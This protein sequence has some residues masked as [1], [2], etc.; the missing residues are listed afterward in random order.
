MGKEYFGDAKKFLEEVRIVEP[1]YDD[2][3][4][5]L[6][7]TGAIEFPVRTWFLMARKSGEVWE[8][9]AVEAFT[10]REALALSPGYTM[11]WGRF[12]TKEQAL[13]A[14]GFLKD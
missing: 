5:F 8:F 10:D 7:Q 2:M 13:R 11:A 14:S 3:R 9:S 4:Q 1:A 6:G 12:D